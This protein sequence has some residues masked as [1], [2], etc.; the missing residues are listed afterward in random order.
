LLGVTTLERGAEAFL[1]NP[2]E[3]AAHTAHDRELISEVVPNGK[4]LA[5]D[6]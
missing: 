4:A 2:Q 5:R 1:L 3:L 6:A